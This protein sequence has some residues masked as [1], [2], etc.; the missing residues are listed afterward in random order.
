VEQL[1]DLQ[2]GRNASMMKWKEQLA[3]DCPKQDAPQLHDRSD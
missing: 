2:Y 3:G 1:G